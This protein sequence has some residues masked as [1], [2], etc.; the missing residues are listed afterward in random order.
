MRTLAI[1]LTLAIAATATAQSIGGPA[2]IPAL[3]EQ[4][5]PVNEIDVPQ[6]NLDELSKWASKL[7]VAV[8]APPE[9]TPSIEI[10]IGLARRKPVLFFS[11]DK[12]GLYVLCLVDP[13]GKSPRITTKRVQVGG[14]V[15]PPEPGPV[16]PQP[17]PAPIPLPGLRVLVIY[18]TDPATNKPKLTR[19]QALI[20][21]GAETR[22]LL[23]N[24]CVK[25]AKGSP[26]FRFFDEE[27]DTS[28]AAQHWRDAMRRPRQALPW[29]IISDGTKGY[30][31][32]LPAN[33]QSFADLL[34]GF[35]A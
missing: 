9:S 18:E 30:E 23:S 8:D 5:F 22:T 21:A 7:I 32:T 4:R 20:V 6:G 19:D 29:L 3:T 10:D 34:K 24:R 1:W 27:A 35:G 12:A 11:A 26:E 2:Q 14:A 15:N 28:N 31:G 13:S 17:T 16:N 33:P 25:D